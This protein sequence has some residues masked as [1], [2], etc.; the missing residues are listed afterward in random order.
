MG[1]ELGCRCG[2][3]A[4]EIDLSGWG[5]ASRVVCYCDDC[6]TAARALKAQADVLGPGSG[7]HIVQS[8]PDRVRIL[9]GREHLAVL[10]LSP[11]G[12]MRWYAGCCDTPMCNTLPNLKLPFVGLVIRPDRTPQ[13]A[14]AVGKGC[15]HVFTTTARP[16]AE[17]P[18]KDVAFAAAGFAILRRMLVALVAGRGGQS[19]FRD[20]QG[21]PVAPVRVLTPEQRHDARPG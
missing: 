12:L 17:A 2:A 9:R 15:A 1:L 8:T 18:R 13:I 7:T 14:A 11:K 20:A 16:R 10:R 4:L 6:Q 3:C 19:P 21:A 5:A